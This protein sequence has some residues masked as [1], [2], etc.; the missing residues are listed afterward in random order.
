MSEFVERERVSSFESNPLGASKVRRGDDARALRQL[1]EIFRRSF[2]SQ[3]GI[4]GLESR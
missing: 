4:G 2:E 1:H 3:P